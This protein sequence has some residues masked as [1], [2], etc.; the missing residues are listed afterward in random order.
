MKMYHCAS[1]INLKDDEQNL[2]SI[3][4]SIAP[5]KIAA[6]I[7]SETPYVFSLNP[8]NG[9]YI[10]D[11]PVAKNVTSFIVHDS[12]LLLT[13]TLGRL[14]CIRLI[15][16]QIEK[17]QTVSLTDDFFSRAIEQGG[18]LISAIPDTPIV[19]L[20]IPRGNLEIISCRLIAVDILEDLLRKGEWKEALGFIRTD[21]LNSNLLIDLDPHRFVDN[22]EKFVDACETAAALNAFCQEIED[23]NVLNTIY[24]KCCLKPYDELKNK[25]RAICYEILKYLEQIDYAYYISTL[26]IISVYHFSIEN[27]LMYVQDLLER[28]KTDETMLKIA[29]VA[30]KTLN[31]HAK[32]EDLFEKALSLYDLELARFVAG[33]SQM[34]PKS[35]E[36]FLKELSP[37]AEVDRRFKIN[38]FLKKP[39]VAI[40]YLLRTP[41]VDPDFALNFIKTHNVAEIAF[42]NLQKGSALFKEVSQILGDKLSSKSKHDEAALIYARAELL[43]DAFREYKLACNWQKAIASVWKLEISDGDRYRLIAEVAEELAKKGDYLNASR[44]YEE[45][46]QNFEK[47]IQLLTKMYYFKEA[48]FLAEKHNRPDFVGEL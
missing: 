39:E 29:T 10:N 14:F 3:T 8:Y 6:Q 48:I 26:V 12:Y 2:L 33:F 43:N 36:P 13:T 40:K 41:E 32:R 22:I 4:L 11:S 18:T 19:I 21:R 44:V 9:F 17:L 25:R 28:S 1:K 31:I 38:V 37:L 24:A 46:L 35:Y 16:T 45:Y 30:V 5:I 27:A 15:K 7:I 34:D 42:R 47:A 20:Q 23:A